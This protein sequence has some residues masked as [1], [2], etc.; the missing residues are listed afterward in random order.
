MQDPSSDP[1]LA[2]I[3]EHRGG[4]VWKHIG[5]ILR[6]HD[7]N[8][9]RVF[10]CDVLGL[11]GGMLMERGPTVISPQLQV[12]PGWLMLGKGERWTLA[13]VG[14]PQATKANPRD[15]GLVLSVRLHDDELVMLERYGAAVH[16]PTTVR[17]PWG[18]GLSTITDPL[19]NVLRLW[20]AGG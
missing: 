12:P 2:L 8:A 14:D 3:R 16:E 10:Y 13:I 18:G 15:V 6:A 4:L 20:S 5:V 7:L 11:T 9:A 1:E 17:A 19:G